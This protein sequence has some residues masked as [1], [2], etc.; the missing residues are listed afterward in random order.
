[1]CGI[2]GS[3]QQKKTE[4]LLKKQSHRGQSTETTETGNFT[5]GNV[6]HS[7]VGN[8]KQPVQDQGIL[9]ANCEIYNWKKLAKNHGFKVENDAELLLKLLDKEG[10]KALKQLDGIY[11]FAYRK[12]NKIILGRDKLG[13]NPIWYVDN[14][15]EFAF[16]SEKQA[17]DDAGYENIR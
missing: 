11:A 12:D 6:L 7:V 9:T 13:V 14:G 15:K 17:L 10:K 2:A 1:M 4:K 8:V 3:R 16:A 5:L